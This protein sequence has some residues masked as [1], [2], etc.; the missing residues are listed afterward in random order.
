MWLLSHNQWGRSRSPKMRG[1][2]LVLYYTSVG[3]SRAEVAFSHAQLT[4]LYPRAVRG[5][6]YLD[7]THVIKSTRLSRIPGA[8]GHG[9][10]FFL[11]V[12]G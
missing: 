2:A 5:T 7:V 11:R 1:I 6:R 4:S 3:D 9:A 12:R 8:H 10:P